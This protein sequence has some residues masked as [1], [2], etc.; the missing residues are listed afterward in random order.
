MVYVTPNSLIPLFREQDVDFYN[1]T[2]KW[3]EE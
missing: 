2:Y 3:R 1:S